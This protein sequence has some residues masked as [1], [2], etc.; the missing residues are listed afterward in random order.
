[1]SVQQVF[2]AANNCKNNARKLRDMAGNETNNNV[3]KLLFE[4]AHHLD[5]GTAELDYILTESTVS[6]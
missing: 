5:V 3:K 2:D 6:I 1:M 4:A